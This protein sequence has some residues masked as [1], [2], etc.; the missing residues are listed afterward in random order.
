MYIA[1]GKLTCMVTIAETRNTRL[2]LNLRRIRIGKLPEGIV[3]VKECNMHCHG[4]FM[5][6][7][8]LR[9]Y[10]A[11]DMKLARS[12]RPKHNHQ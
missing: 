1:K 4:V 3:F 6:H 10:L 7:R 12:V 8:T 5:W 2:T 11:S 9:E